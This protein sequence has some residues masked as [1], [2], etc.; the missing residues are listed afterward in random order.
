M[1]RNEYELLKTRSKIYDKF[2]TKNLKLNKKCACV[3][4]VRGSKIYNQCL[5]DKK[6]NKKPLIFYTID[7]ALN[8]KKI[9]KVIL[10]TSDVKLIKLVKKKY[11]NKIFL[12]KRSEDLSIENTFYRDAVISAVKSVY[13]KRSRLFTNLK[14]RISSKRIFLYR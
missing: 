6:L 4:P 11:K 5:S 14:F 7:Q 9:D 2:V 13:K 3:I 1:S 8:S 12:H 10:S